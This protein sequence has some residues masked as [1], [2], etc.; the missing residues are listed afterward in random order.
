MLGTYFLYLSILTF[1]TAFVWLYEKADCPIIA[2]LMLFIAFLIVF[3]PAALRYNIGTDYWSYVDM[4]QEIKNGYPSQEEIAWL[5][6]NV[7]IAKTGLDV[8]W[9]F[10]ISSFI[11]YLF[12]FK[13]YPKDGAWILHFVFICSFYLISYST[14]RGGV[15]FAIM[16]FAIVQY[17]QTR[18]LFRFYIFLLLALLFHKSSILYIIVPILISRKI[19]WSFEKRWFVYGIYTA[20]ALFFLFRLSLAIWLLDNPISDYLGYASYASDPVFSKPGQL[21]TAVGIMLHVAVLMIP[22]LFRKQFIDAGGISQ[23]LVPLNII[24]IFSIAA[25]LGAI[26]FGRVERLFDFCYFLTPYCALISLKGWPKRLSV[27]F[28]IFA[29]GALFAKN[30]E[31]DQSTR[32]GGMRIS[33][34][35]SILNKQ[36]DHSVSVSAFTCMTQEGI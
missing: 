9:I 35:V 18:R 32:C 5:W 20:L 1:S 27:L 25:A 30:I 21:G 23:A 6:L 16:F 7:F 22:L 8:Q 13:A 15:A 36:D 2:R 14:V 17:I 4:F 12:I 3:L 26:I 31:H 29:W 28:V 34:Y 11:T 24:T 10:V 33:P 19:F